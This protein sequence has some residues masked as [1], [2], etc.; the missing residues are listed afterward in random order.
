MQLPAAFRDY[1]AVFDRELQAAVSKNGLPLY[2][3]AR[4]HLGWTDES[5]QPAAGG[6]GKALRPSLCLF[7]C[8][9]LGGTVDRAMPAAVAI[10]LVHSFSLVHDDIQDR[11]TERRHRPTVWYLWGQRQG[12]ATG[13]T[14]W[15]LAHRALHRATDCGATG[16][17]LLRADR[18]LTE[19]A[20]DMIEGQA[21]DI[22]FEGRIDVGLDGYL[23]MISRKTGALIGCALELG[24][25]LGAAPE[26]VVQSFRRGGQSLGLAFQIRDDMLGVWGE[27]EAL[28]KPVGA[29]II[30][31]KNSLP[32]AFTLK[33]ATGAARDQLLAVYNKAEIEPEDVE[34]VLEVMD[35]F[36]ARSYSRGLAEE[37]CATALSELSR[38]ELSTEA[39]RSLDDLVNFL[40][41]RDR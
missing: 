36:H 6:S 13:V 35:R 1:R 31:K 2:D 41:A 11:D 21:M 32:V 17:Q 28:G 24:A 25:I 33:Q 3:M 16:A 19:A 12:I 15:S 20:R 40:L 29:D 23:A 9:A 4:Y 38:L 30:R 14:L 8:E 22:E 7:A 10:E 27:T 39:R 34:T 18:A 5:G 26:P 37:T